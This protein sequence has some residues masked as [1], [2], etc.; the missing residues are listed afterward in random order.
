MEMVKNVQLLDENSA[1]PVRNL[2]LMGR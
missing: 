1:G 2:N